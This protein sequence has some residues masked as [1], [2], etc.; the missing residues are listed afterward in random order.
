MP[1]I[2]F[3]GYLRIKART[4]YDDCKYFENRHKRP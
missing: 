2:L 1:V 3:P 4:A